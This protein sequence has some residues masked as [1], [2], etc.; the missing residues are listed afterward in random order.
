MNNPF[1]WIAAILI[2]CAVLEI[3]GAWMDDRRGNR[4]DK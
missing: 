4:R 1:L 2:V 3:V